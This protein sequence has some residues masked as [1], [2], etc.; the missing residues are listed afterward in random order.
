MTGQLAEGTAEK[1]LAD[2]A[3]ISEILEKNPELHGIGNYEYGWPT[4]TTSAPTHAVV[5]TKR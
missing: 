4:R 5:S 3:V 2:G 1:A